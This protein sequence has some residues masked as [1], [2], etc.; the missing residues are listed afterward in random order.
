MKWLMNAKVNKLWVK[1]LRSGKY[2]Q[3]KRM[4]RGD[5]NERCCLGVLCEVYREDTQ[6]GQWGDGEFLPGSMGFP[7]RALLPRLVTEWAGLGHCKGDEV[8]IGGVELFLSEHNDT[9]QS[10]LKI[11][12]AIEEQL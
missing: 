10:F 5:G 11:A 4:L 6:Q 3:T 2:K 12:T 9:G 1:A 8:T 7:N